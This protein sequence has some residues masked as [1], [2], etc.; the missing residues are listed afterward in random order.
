MLETRD[1]DDKTDKE[2]EAKTDDILHVKTKRKKD[3]RDRKRYDKQTDRQNQIKTSEK[4]K[5]RRGGC[6]REIESGRRKYRQTN[7]QIILREIW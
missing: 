5:R 6:R 4:K 2:V 1:R 3:A 7:C